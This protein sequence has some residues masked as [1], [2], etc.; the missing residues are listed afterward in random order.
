MFLWSCRIAMIHPVACGVT[1]CSTF[2]NAY[3]AQHDKS[4]N[5]HPSWALHASCHGIG[6][7]NQGCAGCWLAAHR[8][9]HVVAVTMTVHQAS[10]CGVDRERVPWLTHGHG[11]A[12]ELCDVCS[13]L[14][15]VVVHQSTNCSQQQPLPHSCCLCQSRGLRATGPL[16]ATLPS[17]QSKKRPCMAVFASPRGPRAGPRCRL[18]TPQAS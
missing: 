8:Q 10:L 7:S 16:L 17:G 18:V 4:N 2:N 12:N 13:Q 14:Q 5:M 11:E 3:K 6:T 9:V 1:G 15:T